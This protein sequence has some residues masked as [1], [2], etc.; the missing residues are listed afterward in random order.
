MICSDCVSP[1]PLKKIVIANS[2]SGQCKYCDLDKE[3]CDSSIL[4]D[5]ILERINEN[6]AI[7]KDLSSYEE[8]MVYEG[9]SDEINVA[10]LD[11][12]AS[13]WIGFS[14][15]DDINSD[16]CD[17]FLGY[18]PQ[19]YVKTDKGHDVLYFEDG[20]LLERNIFEDKW[21]AFIEEVT[22]AHR[23]FNPTAQSFLDSIFS[24][25]TADD[26]AIKPECITEVKTGEMLY[27]ART[28]RTYK[29]AKVLQSDPASQFGPPPKVMAGSQR[30]TPSGISA[31]YCGFDR[32][33]CLSEIRAITG[34]I[35]VSVAITPKTTMKFLDLRNLA[36][37]EGPDLTWLE[38]GFLNSCHLKSFISSLVKKMSKPKG[39]NEE[40]SYLSTQVVFEYL[41]LKFHNQIEGLIFPSVQTGER[42]SNAVIFPESCVVSGVKYDEDELEIPAEP[43]DD[44]NPFEEPAVRLMHVARS[45]MFHKVT[46]IE[47]TSTD[48]DNIHE[49]FM[50]DLTRQR[51]GVK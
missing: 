23:F 51:L 16:L 34:D 6:L 24:F 1:L 45:T 31:M 15:D 46:A 27:R 12:V 25:T 42:G 29:D 3:C 11:V 40:L 13:E 37:L 21:S 2:S 44:K 17:D 22:H 49:A 28:V 8:Y 48:Y 30:M 35:V 18:V 9:G 33:T 38:E 26:G 4:F 32:S 19:S 43:I 10:S 39:R 7:D 14:T 5:Y 20:G 47:T 50:D 36:R 41:R